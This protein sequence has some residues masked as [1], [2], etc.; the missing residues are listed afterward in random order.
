MHDA[1]AV[2]RRQRIGDLKRSIECLVDRQRAMRQPLRKRVAVEQ[3]HHQ[4]VD[5]VRIAD[6]IDNTDVGMPQRG[7]GAR[8]AVEPIA[9]RAI[10]AQMF[11]KD[12][13]G[14]RAAEPRIRRA[15]DLP[16]PTT[17]QWRIDA[18]DPEAPSD[19]RHAIGG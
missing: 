15:I 10:L 1:A 11:R 7:G 14:D 13:D 2:Y 8:L 3:L 6:V 12:F 16:H 9:K 17:G 4:E 19:Q 18:I 5:A